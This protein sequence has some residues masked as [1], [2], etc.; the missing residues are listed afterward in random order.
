MKFKNILE[1]Y[2]GLPLSKR[3]INAVLKDG[4][5]IIFFLLLIISDVILNVE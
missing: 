1:W 4:V 5:Q 2:N 3:T